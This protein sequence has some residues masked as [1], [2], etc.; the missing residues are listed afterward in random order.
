MVHTTVFKSLKHG[1][2]IS[3]R[4]VIKTPDWKM[5]TAERLIKAL[6]LPIDRTCS[7]DFDPAKVLQ[8]PLS[9]YGIPVVAL[10]MHGDRPWNWVDIPSFDLITLRIVAA[11]RPSYIYI[12]NRKL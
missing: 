2:V 7:W 5:G 1:S 10:E 11:A 9:I 12:E 4:I 3:P 8:A 6:C